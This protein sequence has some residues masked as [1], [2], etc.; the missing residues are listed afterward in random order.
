MIEQFPG[1]CTSW[2]NQGS[3]VI[4][5]GY[6]VTYNAFFG[7]ACPATLDCYQAVGDR[8]IATQTR[9]TG[10]CQPGNAVHCSGGVCSKSL[11]FATFG[12]PTVTEYQILPC[13]S[14]AGWALGSV[15]VITYGP[16]AGTGACCPLGQR[17]GQCDSYQSNVVMVGAPCGVSG[18]EE[19][20][21]F[22]RVT[23]PG[24]CGDDNCGQPGRPSLWLP[25]KEL[26]GVDGLTIGGIRPVGDCV[27]CGKGQN[28]TPA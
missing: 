11:P 7:Q 24:T 17:Y 12:E 13:E 27:G 22:Q 15:P 25:P 14:L 10:D 16:S 18:S 19:C 5:G 23:T 8:I 28:R 26:V 20:H 9:F 1:G 21:D 6:T 4:G 3:A 2:R